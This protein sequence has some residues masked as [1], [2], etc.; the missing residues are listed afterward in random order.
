MSELIKGNTTDYKITM[1]RRRTLSFLGL[2]F[3]AAVLL[4][5]S[6]PVTA[7]ANVY[8]WGIEGEVELG[9]GFDVWANVTNDEINND[10]DP[11]IKNVTIRVIGPNMSHFGLMSHNGTYYTGSVPAFPN[12]GTFNVYLIAY[13]Q[14]DH[15][16][17]SS[18]VYVVYDPEAPEPIDPTVTMPIVI[19]SSVALMIVVA[20]L[21]LMYDKRKTTAE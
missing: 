9:Q 5:S 8:D 11:G 1:T 14:T 20:A 12:G 3:V 10:D 2:F 21:A 15:P 16:R 18:N 6:S 4:S 17:I 13:N 19:G 7:L